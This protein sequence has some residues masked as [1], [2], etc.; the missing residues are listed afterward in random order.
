MRYLSDLTTNSQRHS[1]KSFF[2][3]SVARN[4]LL[5]NLRNLAILQENFSKP[6]IKNGTFR[7][8]S[9]STL[10]KVFLDIFN[11]H[12]KA[13]GKEYKRQKKTWR[14]VA[15]D[16][17]GYFLFAAQLSSAKSYLEM[18]C[19]TCFVFKEWIHLFSCFLSCNRSYTPDTVS[20]LQGGMWTAH[21]EQHIVNRTLWT[22]HCEENIVNSTYLSTTS[23]PVKGTRQILLSGIFLLRGGR[24]VPPI[25]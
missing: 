10:T 24:R 22:A 17:L 9:I 1:E 5:W 8:L 15:P 21:C 11:N 14:K 16:V 23:T 7:K 13:T 12:S 25:R 3:L 19:H 2:E 20:R 6:K 4:F 18:G